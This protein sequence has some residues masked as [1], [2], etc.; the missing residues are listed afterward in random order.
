MSHQVH[1]V[2]ALAFAEPNVVRVGERASAQLVRR[3]TCRRTRVHAQVAQVSIEDRLDLIAYGLRERAR[4]L[5]WQRIFACRR[6]VVSAGCR[7]TIDARA[8]LDT[9]PS[10]RWVLRLTRPPG[11]SVSHAVR[12]SLA[13][14]A[15]LVDHELLLDRRSSLLEREVLQGLGGVPIPEGLAKEE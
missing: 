10:Y 8:V 1:V 6:P 4:A 9:R 5:R 12:L 7:V 3:L 15:R 13:L 2:W 14:V 11:D